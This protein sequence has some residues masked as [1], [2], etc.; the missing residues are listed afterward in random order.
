MTQPTDTEQATILVVDDDHEIRTL[1][2]D[3][4]KKQ[5]YRALLAKDGADMMKHLAVNP[6][7]QLIVLGC[8]DAWRRWTVVAQASAFRTQS[9]SS[10]VNVIGSRRRCRSYRR[11]GNGS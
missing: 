1:L 10:G 7:V 4:L 9:R 6:A 3:L 2:G 8:H 5:G 11:A